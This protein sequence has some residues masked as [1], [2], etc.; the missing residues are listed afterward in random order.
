M[1][2]VFESMGLLTINDY[3]D[4]AKNKINYGWVDKDGNKHDGVNDAVS[5]SLQSLK[6]VIDSRI[7]IC[8]DLT[9]LSRSFFESKFV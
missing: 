6:E 3:F 1:K 7:G 9:E 4:F 2:E 8:W 5:Y